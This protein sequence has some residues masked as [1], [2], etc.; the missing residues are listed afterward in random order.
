MARAHDLLDA[1]HLG[2]LR[3][4]PACLWEKLLSLPLGLDPFDRTVLFAI[5][6]ALQG[7]RLKGYLL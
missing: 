7:I 1:L 2:P 3:G 4:P 6:I 5:G